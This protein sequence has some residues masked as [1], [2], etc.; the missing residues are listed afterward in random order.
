MKKSILALSALV[1]LLLGSTVMP[2][3][4]HYY[5]HYHGWGGRGLGIGLGLGGLGLGLGLGALGPR[6]YYGGYPYGYW[7]NDYYGAYPYGGANVYTAP[8]PYYGYGGY[9]WY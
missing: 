7:D 8:T 2:A 6:A 4:A 5:G 9:Y 3:D 1:M